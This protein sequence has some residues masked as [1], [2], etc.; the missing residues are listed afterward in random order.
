MSTRRGLSFVLL[1]PSMPCPARFLPGEAYPFSSCLPACP[2]QQDVYLVRPILCPL[3]SQHVLSSNMS[4]WRGLSSVLLSPTMSC[5]ARCL[6]RRGLSSVLLSPSMPCPARCL[7]GEAYPL[8]SCLPACPV[9]QDVYL[10]R[11]IL[12][13]LVSQHVLSSKMST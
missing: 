10:E 11:P 12:C 13:P 6:P 5:P 9:Q 2:N 8:S 3:V 7:P 1:S 4:T